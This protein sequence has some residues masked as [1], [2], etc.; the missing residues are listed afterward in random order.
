MVITFLRSAGSRTKG[1]WRVIEKATQADIS[2]AEMKHSSLQKALS[3][4][5]GR[6]H[7][8]VHFFFY[9][10]IK[11]RYPLDIRG[12]SRDSWVTTELGTGSLRHAAGVLTPE[13]LRA[14]FNSE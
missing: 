3:F 14:V 11:L 4:C 7:I 10:S 12:L 1:M 13:D 9:R 2:L 8:H 5:S 6:V